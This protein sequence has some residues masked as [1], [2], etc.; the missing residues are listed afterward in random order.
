MASHY[1]GLNLQRFLLE[2][3]DIS[4]YKIK[5]DN[6]NLE[7]EISLVSQKALEAL[8]KS[9]IEGIPFPYLLNRVDFYYS[10]FFVDP[11]VLIPRP[12]TEFLVDLIVQNHQGRVERILDVGTGSG[13]IVLSLIKHGVGKSGLG[14]DISSKALEVANKNLKTLH[15][16]NQVTLI[17]SDKLKNVD[18]M[19]DLIVS[20]PPY[21]K[22]YSHKDLVHPK[23]N[24]FEPHEALYLPDDFYAMWFE[25][26]FVQIRSHLHGVFYMEGH[27]W[28]LETQAEIIGKLGFT[29]I[30]VLRDLSGCKR[31]LKASFYP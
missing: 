16:E 20:N 18:G 21:I 23:V 10:E 8:K 12:E 25:D 30:E 17:T 26:F 15:L 6:L 31:F 3:R 7:S 24:E 27:E 28:E 14:V 19:F 2:V 4:Q 1:P 5:N 13:V 11:S 22:E 9:F 29:G